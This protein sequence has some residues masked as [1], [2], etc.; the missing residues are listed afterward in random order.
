MLHGILQALQSGEGCSVEELARRLGTTPAVVTAALEQLER[1]GRVRRVVMATR[2]AH[3]CAGCT[4]GC[5][6]AGPPALRWE[7][8]GR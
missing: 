5:A 8:C 7:L 2:C 1:M 3:G 4:G 6:L